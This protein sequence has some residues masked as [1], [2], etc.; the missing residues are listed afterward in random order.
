MATKNK[1]EMT[2]VDSPWYTAEEAAAYLKVSIASINRWQA[3]GALPFYKVGRTRRFRQKDLD[4][5][6]GEQ[7]L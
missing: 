7:R 3:D 1:P 2:T 4:A 6:L 5:L